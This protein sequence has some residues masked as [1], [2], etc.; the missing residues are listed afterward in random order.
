[1]RDDPHL[2]QILEV[3]GRNMYERE[4]VSQLHHALQTAMLA[5]M[6]GAAPS[7]IAAA[8]L[9]DVGHIVDTRFKDGQENDI[10]RH[11]EVIGAAFLGRVFPDAVTAPIKMHVAAKKYLCAVEPSY[12]E[13]LSKASIRSL[14]LQGGPMTRDEAAA[15]IAQPYAEDAVRLRR[16]DDFAKDPDRKTPPLKHFLDIADSVRTVNV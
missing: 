7:L 13:G 11:H 6:D 16:W 10:D 5:E 15:F 9:H 14:G 3:A 12:I 1:M 4:D 2:E 8:L